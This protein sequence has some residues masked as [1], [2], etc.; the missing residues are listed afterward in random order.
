MACIVCIL[1]TR[2]RSCALSAPAV[3]SFISLLIVR[4]NL[5]AHTADRQTRHHTVTIT[6][7]TCA[8]WECCKS[9]EIPRRTELHSSPGSIII[10]HIFYAVAGITTTPKSTGFNCC[11]HSLYYHPF[12]IPRS[13]RKLSWF[14]VF[15]EL[16]CHHGAAQSHPQSPPP[17]CRPCRHP[18]NRECN[19][20]AA[21]VDA[22]A[23]TNNYSHAAGDAKY[24]N[25]Q[26]EQRLQHLR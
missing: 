12:C 15:R 5:M 14:R 7:A 24:A 18:R 10:A 25:R 17:E 2:L 9:I 11:M 22:G 6:I 20:D 16:S 3:M 19:R 21:V 1:Y 8:T 4:I 26:H 13:Q 23:P